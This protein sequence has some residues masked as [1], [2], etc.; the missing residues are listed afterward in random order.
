VSNP[1]ASLGDIFAEGVLEILPDGRAFLRPGDESCQPG[2]Y[3]PAIDDIHVPGTLMGKVHLKQGDTV[4][5][6]VRPPARGE[7]HFSLVEIDYV[8]SKPPVA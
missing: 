3:R 7:T 1:D 5:G 6:K 4:S 8:N 2:S